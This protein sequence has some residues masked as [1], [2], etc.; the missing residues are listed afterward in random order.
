MEKVTALCYAVAMDSGITA[1]KRGKD[2][3]FSIHWSKLIS[4]DRWTIATSVPAVGGVYEIYWMDDHK[5]LRLLTVG[6]ARYGGLRSEIRRL[7]DPQLVENP[8][9]IEILNNKKIYFRYATANSADD[10]ADVVWFFRK[11][12]FP[13]NPGVAH[14]GRFARIYM[15]EWAPD[16]VR[17]V[18]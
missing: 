10:M 12:Y 7:T 15:N 8:E 4:A 6:N 14:S 9:V 17:W 1:R 16:K 11:T 18:D 2:V 3:F 5:H 13:E